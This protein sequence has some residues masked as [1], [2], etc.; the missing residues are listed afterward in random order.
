[1]GARPVAASPVTAERFAGDPVVES[2]HGPSNA[3]EGEEDLA[4]VSISR[5][6]REDGVRTSLTVMVFALR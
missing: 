3:A 5:G 6:G 1:M 2:V 4:S